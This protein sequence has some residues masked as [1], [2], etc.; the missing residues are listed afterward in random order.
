MTEIFSYAGWIGISA[1]ENSEFEDDV[2][3]SDYVY[4]C[5]LINCGISKEAANL[6]KEISFDS[7]NPIV[8]EIKKYKGELYIMWNI[9]PCIAFMPH[10]VRREF[11]FDANQI[12]FS[13]NIVIPEE[14]RNY[15][16]GN[17][18]KFI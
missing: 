5:K 12:D 1:D 17:A 7:T 6:F 9:A 10:E 14:F 16:A 2:V 8:A 18:S 15:V 3:F 11:D 13:Q 4:V